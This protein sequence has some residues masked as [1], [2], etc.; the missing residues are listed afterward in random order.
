MTIISLFCIRLNIFFFPIPVIKSVLQMSIFRD[1]SRW[2][3]GGDHQPN[4]ICIQFRFDIHI[5]KSVHVL[6]NYNYSRFMWRMTY[7]HVV[8][9]VTFNFEHLALVDSTV[10]LFL[11]SVFLSN[12]HIVEC[13]SFYRS[14]GHKNCFIIKHSFKITFWSLIFVTINALI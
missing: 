9:D 11:V 10:L 1:N 13:K 12:V 5:S 8:Q 3:N 2:R 4:G 6:A 14:M 7:L